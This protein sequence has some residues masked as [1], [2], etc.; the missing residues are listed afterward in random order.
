MAQRRSVFLQS[1]DPQVG[2][3]SFVWKPELRA[4]GECSAGCEDRWISCGPAGGSGERHVRLHHGRDAPG[5]CEA[6]AGEMLNTAL[7]YLVPYLVSCTFDERIGFVL[8]SELD[9]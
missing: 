5:L 4:F 2:T 7:S 1:A 8:Q 3:A 6:V 9:D